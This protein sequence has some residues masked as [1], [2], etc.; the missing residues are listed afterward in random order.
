M[1]V[2]ASGAR[3][4]ARDY[5]VAGAPVRGEGRRDGGRDDRGC[6]GGHSGGR[7]ATLIGSLRLPRGALCLGR[8]HGDDRG[9]AGSALCGAGVAGQDHRLSRGD[10]GV[11]C[12]VSA[13]CRIGARALGSA[14]LGLI[15]GL[16]TTTKVKFSEN[17]PSLHKSISPRRTPRPVFPSSPTPLDRVRS[18]H[19]GT[20]LSFLA[21][22]LYF[23]KSIP[24]LEMA[25][26]V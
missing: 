15:R 21:I 25:D 20:F 22:F 19:Q 17:S 3:G 4:S 11:H 12:F 7:A 23:S 14:P 13:W 24:F 5:R 16:D 2:R 10:R 26:S 9:G 8:S 6:G 1:V 18:P